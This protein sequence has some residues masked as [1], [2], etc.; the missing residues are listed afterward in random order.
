MCG[1]SLIYTNMDNF[2]TG[3]TKC[4]N[5]R[6]NVREAYWAET[7]VVGSGRNETFAY[8]RAGGAVQTHYET[9]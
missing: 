4:A 3:S 8:N 2:S 7:L 1:S 6:Q 9:Q 5:A